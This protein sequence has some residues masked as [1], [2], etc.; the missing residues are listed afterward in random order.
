MNQKTIEMKK[1]V[2]E[3]CKNIVNIGGEITD[4]EVNEDLSVSIHFKDHN[5]DVIGGFYKVCTVEFPKEET[6]NFCPQCGAKVN[7]LHKFCTQCGAP[8]KVRKIDKN[9]L[10]EKINTITGIDVIGHRIMV[11]RD[12]EICDKMIELCYRAGYTLK[13][14][15][16]LGHVTVFTIDDD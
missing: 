8:L 3:E 1:L 10:L 9:Q 16:S 6:I 7:E 13:E 11:P 2:E 14:E 5:C 12:Q 4:I 15:L